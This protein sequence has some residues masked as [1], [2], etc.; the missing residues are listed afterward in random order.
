MGIVA[1]QSI[2]GSIFSY[3][4]AFI[5]F[6]NTLFIVTAMMENEVYGLIGVIVEA[7]TLLGSFSMMGI[8]SA[9][10]KFFPFFKSKDGTHNGFFFY[11]LVIPLIGFAIFFSLAI[12]FKASIISYFSENASLFVDYF[13]W[14]FPLA[15]FFAYQTVFATYSNVLM[16]VVVPRFVQ[17]VLVRVLNMAIFV[18]Y[19]FHI[20]NLQWLIALQVMVYGAAMLVNLFY[21]SRIGKLTLKHDISFVSPELRGQI[22]RYSAYTLLAVIGSTI[23]IKIDTFMV[24]GVLGL[25]KLGIYRVALFMGVIVEIPSRS[26]FAIAQPIASEAIKNDDR[27][28]LSQLLKKVSI[29]LLLIGSAIFLL[30]YIN[31]FNIF[32][33]MPNGDKYAAGRDVM[34]FIALANLVNITFMFNLY[35][36]QLSKYYIYYLPFLL[37]LSLLGILGNYFLLPVMDMTGGAVAK[38]ITYVLVAVILTAFVYWKLKIHPFTLRHLY[39]VLIL[40]GGIGVDFLLPVIPNAIAD[41]I[42]RTLIIGGVGAVLVYRLKISPDAN[43]IADNLLDK[44]KGWKSKK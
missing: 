2:K 28:A 41:G 27:A 6:V 8:G 34:V 5:G 7:G 39:M 23:M 32:E 22:A 12:I 35:V 44:A 26:L 31:R 37:L 19:G 20:I 33:I 25:A 24:G 17:E 4:G 42:Y 13:W 38:I 36:L 40:L 21:I 10:F 11:L 29:N 9:G 18:L 1:R 16:R 43:A 30:I 3:L 15:F 14:I